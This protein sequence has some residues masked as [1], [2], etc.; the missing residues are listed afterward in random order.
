[1]KELRLLTGLLL[2]FLVL[3]LA[4]QNTQAGSL[5]ESMNNQFGLLVN[6]TDPSY[7][8]TGRKGV[9]TGGNLSARAKIMDPQ[10]VN[11][12]A[13]SMSAGCGGWNIFGG[14]FSFISSEQIVAMLR[15]IAS[16]AIGLAFKMALDAISPQLNDILSELE[17]GMQAMNNGAM[18]SC[19]IAQ[20][21]TG[22]LRGNDTNWNNGAAA[23]ATQHFGAAWDSLKSWKWGSG[24]GDEAGE[25]VKDDL[26]EADPEQAAVIA[27]I[28]TGN[29]TWNALKKSD[30]E[31]WSSVGAGDINED[32]LSLIGTVI[33]CSPG[34]DNC[35][36]PSGEGSERKGLLK[37]TKE[38]G[39]YD[40]QVFMDGTTSG[41]TVKAYRCGSSAVDKEH[42]LDPKSTDVAMV[43]LKKYVREMLCGN[44]G[45][46]CATSTGGLIYRYR[47]NVKN[48]LGAPSAADLKMMAAF[49]SIG[50]WGSIKNIVLANERSGRNYVDTVLPLVS[51][52][53]GHDVVMDMLKALKAATA[54]HKN[55]RDMETQA[56]VTKTIEKFKVEYDVYMNQNKIDNGAMAYYDDVLRNA[57]ADRSKVLPTNN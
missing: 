40:F 7:I 55:G 56:L 38:G 24:G 27:E 28:I 5:A 19:Q 13:P 31:N 14:S 32:L 50:A 44:E 41:Q 52:G 54:S 43:G 4:P 8:D 39:L 47:Y 15:S 26:N 20:N 25:S 46:T 37:S 53:V 21:L 11:F 12:Q 34:K 22:A 51:A 17:A 57:T 33:I 35:P 23:E 6:N 49:T 42:C 30:A 48:N 45:E 9:V 18:N 1:M 2:T 16:N 3:C 10:W 29:L 36:M